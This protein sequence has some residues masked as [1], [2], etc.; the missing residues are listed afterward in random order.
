M[1]TEKFISKKHEGEYLDYAISMPET[2]EKVPLIFWIHGA[3]GVGNDI[4]KYMTTSPGFLRAVEKAG[5]T[6]AVM[7]P[8]CHARM[9]FELFEVLTEFI[10][11]ARQDERF[12]PDRIYIIGGSM[13]GYTVWQMILSHPDW[14]AAAIPICG[15]GMYWNAARLKKLPIWAFHGAL[16]TVVL[17]EESIHM[18][19][20]INRNGGHAK[21][22]IFADAEHDSWT[23][24]LSSD[25]TWE[26]L[27][28]Q[29]KGG[30]AE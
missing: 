11:T 23:P 7:A 20:A 16:D 13:G 5:S 12:D 15:G 9:W 2:N 30:A 10:D 28:S 8:Q 3:G 14:F 29:V 19:K 27:L 26:W 21:I 6:C 22:T 18:V 17:P 1:T 24:A 25:E 4:N